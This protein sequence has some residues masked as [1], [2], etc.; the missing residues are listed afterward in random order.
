MFIVVRQDAWSKTRCILYPVSSAVLQAMPTKDVVPYVSQEDAEDCLIRAI[1]SVLPAVARNGVCY[2]TLVLTEVHNS[3]VLL[4]G[5]NL[6]SVTGALCPPPSLAVAHFGTHAVLDLNFRNTRSIAETFQRAVWFVLQASEGVPVTCYAAY[7]TDAF[8]AAVCMDM[9]ALHPPGVVVQ[10]VGDIDVCVRAPTAVPHVVPVLDSTGVVL[11]GRRAHLSPLFSHLYLRILPTVTVGEVDS[12]LRMFGTIGAPTSVSVPA[13]RLTDV[14]LVGDEKVVDC[15]TAPTVFFELVDALRALSGPYSISEV[16][17]LYIRPTTVVPL[18]VKGVIMAKAR[19]LVHLRSQE[20]EDAKAA[21]RDALQSPL[22][23]LPFS[24]GIVFDL[25]L[26]NVSME[27]VPSYFHPLH[28]L[29]DAEGVGFFTMLYLLQWRN[30]LTR[31]V[32]VAH[33]RVAELGGQRVTAALASLKTFRTGLLVQSPEHAM[34]RSI[35]RVVDGSHCFFINLGNRDMFELGSRNCL[36]QQRAEDRNVVVAYF[37]GEALKLLPPLLQPDH[38]AH[39][40]A[41]LTEGYMAS[42]KPKCETNLTKVYERTQFMVRRIRQEVTG[43]KQAEG[44][45]ERSKR[46]A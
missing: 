36:Q 35:H 43:V 45:G 11:Y 23:V 41:V 37:F 31:L 34:V 40:A 32:E 29:S 26:N 19:A 1:A 15:F 44:G 16:L 42:L 21:I 13:P 25:L 6:D 14:Q 38:C 20:Q 3:M 12:V 7:C 18:S 33:T 5:S 4:C 17:S 8:T 9:P 2:V 24:D 27:A 46:R 10:T 22:T 28:L 30:T 39:A